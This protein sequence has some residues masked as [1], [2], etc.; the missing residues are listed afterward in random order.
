MAIHGAVA[1]VLE[2]P[3]GAV[4]DA[5]GRR[6]TLVGGAALM[7]GSLTAFAFAR[8]MALF[9]VAE[10]L[11]AAGRAAISGSLEAW[12]V[13]ARRRLD[14]DAPLRRP[15]SRAS[16]FGALGLALGALLGGVV[17]H[18]GFGLA[19]RGDD[20][21]LIYSPAVLLGAALALGYLV[22]VA[23]LVTGPGSGPAGTS[24]ERGLAA[25]REVAS[26]AAGSLR[27]SVAVRLLLTAA[28]G[29]GVC[30]AAVETLWQPRLADLLGGA[31]G[32]TTLFG[33]LV[34]VSM[35]AVAAGSALAP[36]VSARLGGEA[37]TL[38]IVAALAGAVTLVG[39]ALARAPWS[40]AIPFVAFYGSLGV[41]E[42]LHQELLH[43]NVPSDARATL[44]S[45][46]SLS[47]QLGGVAS[48]LTLPR[49]AAGAGIPAA[50]WVCAGVMTAVGLIVR[51]LPAT[52]R[53]ARTR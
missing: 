7:A 40:F 44:L 6:R 38:Y 12:F 16:A 47:E 48:G 42:P 50:F 22:A 18:I 15:L 19:A 45:A 10:A 49:L 41:I 29:F 14:P 21:M 37:R 34:A 3:S 5:V 52:P 26:T 46:A 25:M 30:V 32:S 28:I 24:P 31:A 23:A 35:L 17:P 43:E 39:L 51:L 4:A 11:L 13:D 2:V 27:T 9:A 53:L 33:V 20:P 1:V 36:A 8:G